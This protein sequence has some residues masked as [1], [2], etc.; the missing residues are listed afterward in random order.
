VVD[1]DTDLVPRG[2]LTGGSRSAQKAGAAVAEATA[3]LV[4][5]S[6]LAAAELLEA[7]AV[8]VVLD[9][10]T[11]RFHVAG[12]PAG[13]TVDW[14]EL[15]ADRGRDRALRCEADFEGEGPTVPFGAYVAVVEVDRHTGAVELRRL[16]SVDDA[17]T[18]INPTL[19]L[20]QVHGGL[21]QGVGQAL[22]EQ[23]TY[24][25]GGNPQT[26]NFADYA[27]PSA[28]ELPS[29]ECR[30]LETPSPNNPLGAK[31][32]AESGTVG[33]PPAVQNAVVDALAHLGVR[34]VDLPLTPERVWRA[35]N[36][37]DPRP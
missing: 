21:G 18:I 3:A 37:L 15:A 8:D 5:Q 36:G 1:G 33:A 35:I 16:V 23:F 20:G 12:A 6:R 17:G 25:A 31:G 28:A 14:T 22:F 24:D 9:T 11:G 32:I 13:R 29:F 10:D 19:A 2:G 4:E 34:H 26:T 27:L 7:T 30:L